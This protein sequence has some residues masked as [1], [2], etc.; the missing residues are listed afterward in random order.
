[1]N[2]LPVSRSKCSLPSTGTFAIRR[3][4]RLS[5]GCSLD[6]CKA[7]ALTRDDRPYMHL[8]YLHRNHMQRTPRLT[9]P[10][11]SPLRRL[12]R[13]ML[14]TLHV[15]RELDE[16]PARQERCGASLADEGDVRALSSGAR[17]S[18]SPEN[19]R[20]SPCVPLPRKWQ[21]KPLMGLEPTT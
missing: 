13:P 1:M 12:R 20:N 4:L 10:H 15:L 18:L 11:S 9:R 14:Q 6:A 17:R 16:R 3:G 19:V 21:K 7:R 5:G 8:H 2:P